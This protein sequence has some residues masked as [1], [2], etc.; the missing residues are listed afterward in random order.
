[1]SKI[2]NED[3][4]VEFVRAARE[5]QAPFEIVAG[6]TRRGV[7][8]ADWAQL[9]LL[10]VSGLSGI[11]KYEPEELIVTAQPATPLA[12]IKAVLAEKGQCLGFD[13][14]DWSQSAGRQW[15]GHAWRARLQRCVAA[16]ASCAMAGRGIRCWAFAPST[17]WAKPF[18][19][20]P[21]W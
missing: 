12:E 9:P 13:P 5:D 16:R 21:R 18:A 15:R 19:A 17:A 4:V 1:M 11:V 8:Q 2:A 3:Q 7:G 14:A 10:D 20:A 6:G